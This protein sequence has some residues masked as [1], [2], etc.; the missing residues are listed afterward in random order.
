MAPSN[1]FSRLNESLLRFKILYFTSIGI[2]STLKTY[3]QLFMKQLGLNPYQVGVLLCITQLTG[4]CLSIC[5]GF[6]VDRFR[7][8][9]PCLITAFTIMILSLLGLSFA[10]SYNVET[11]CENVQA[12][13]NQ[14]FS[15]YCQHHSECTEQ[16]FVATDRSWLYTEYR[17]RYTMYKLFVFLLPLEVC[18]ISTYALLDVFTM[19]VLQK[20]TDQLPFQR[21][22]GALGWGCINFIASFIMS[23]TKSNI[24]Y[25]GIAVSVVDFSYMFIFLIIII[26]IT[27]PL[28]VT[29][30][31]IEHNT[32]ASHSLQLDNDTLKGITN[33]LRNWRNLM[34]ILGDGILVGT[35]YGFKIAFVFWRVDDL[36]G[37]KKLLGVAIIIHGAMEFIVGIL[38]SKLLQLFSCVQIIAFGAF[39]YA[40]DF[41]GYAVMQTPIWTLVLQA[42]EGVAFFCTYIF[43]LVYIANTTHPRSLASITFMFSSSYVSLGRSMGSSVGGT[44]VQKFGIQN[45]FMMYSVFATILS[46]LLGTTDL[47]TRKNHKPEANIDDRVGSDISLDQTALIGQLPESD[48]EQ[49]ANYGSS[50]N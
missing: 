16:D 35:L 37:G 12:Q 29:I 8:R 27:L 34:F 5:V 28:V 19:N 48:S 38:G 13:F 18:F 9:K 2:V 17:I 42:I 33:F 31:P 11:S 14:S 20:D 21:A 46:V 32:N 3:M 25:C 49:M 39:M 30:K 36:G 7:I 15:L 4:F 22:F 47:L 24:Q 43:G 10:F 23:L 45:A 44:L 40:L 50:N 26:S 6:I 41:F 1:L